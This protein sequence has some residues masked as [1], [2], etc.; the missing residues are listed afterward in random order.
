[1][2]VVRF[3]RNL[4]PKAKGQNLKLFN[5]A[6]ASEIHE[7]NIHWLKAHQLLLLKSENYENLSKNLTLKLDE[8]IFI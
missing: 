2:F 4:F 8:E 6:D 7:A 3:V 5:Y 1:M